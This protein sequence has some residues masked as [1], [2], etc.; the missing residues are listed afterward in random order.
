M[1]LEDI[2][3]VFADLGE[4]AFN[5]LPVALNHGNLLLV[6]L[7]LLLLLDGGDDTPGCAAGPNNIFVSNGQK[8][9]FLDGEFLV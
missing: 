6:P 9:T 8:I 4:L 3:N 2:E 1:L 5:L 7:A